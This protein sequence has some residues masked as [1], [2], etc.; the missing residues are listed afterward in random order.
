MIKSYN[1]EIAL[2]L[3][4][5]TYGKIRH[6]KHFPKISRKCLHNPVFT[7]TTKSTTSAPTLNK[8]TRL[9]FPIVIS[10]VKFTAVSVC[11]EKI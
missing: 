10:F 5:N 9:I 1:M 8:N 11:L 4:K 7:L 6:I 3:K 2:A